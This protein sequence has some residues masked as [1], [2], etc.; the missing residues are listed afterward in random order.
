VFFIVLILCFYLR[1]IYNSTTIS[2]SKGYRS[3]Q[4][5]TSSGGSL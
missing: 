2:D 1:S 4:Y 3:K 5:S